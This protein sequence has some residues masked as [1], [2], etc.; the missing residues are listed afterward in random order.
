VPPGPGRVRLCATS[1]AEKLFLRGLL[2]CNDFTPI[3]AGHPPP[4]A[5]NRPGK[6]V[7]ALSPHAREPRIE[8]A[9]EGRWSRMQ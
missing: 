3:G 7:P 1:V 4:R 6:P 2:V 9:R 5:L 8:S